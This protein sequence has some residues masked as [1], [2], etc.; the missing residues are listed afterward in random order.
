MS[1]VVV[2]QDDELDAR[3]ANSVEKAFAKYMPQRSNA[4]EYMT[5]K[6]AADYNRISLVTLHQYVN[7]GLLTAYKVSG[8]T[9]FKRSEVEDAAKKKLVYRYKHNC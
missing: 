3:I 1:K 7:R 5:R 8:R 9:L 6:E 2:I 4:E